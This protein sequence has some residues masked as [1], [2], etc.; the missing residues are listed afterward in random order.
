MQSNSRPTSK[1]IDLTQT[2][3]AEIPSWDGDCGFNLSVSVDYTDCV[4]PDL[5]RV[6]SISTRAGMGTH[7][8]APAHCISGAK[9]VD[10]LVI[11]NLITS[12]VTIHL[13]QFADENYVVMPEIVH[14]FERENGQIEP[15][16]F[17]IFYTGWSKYWNNPIE[18]RNGLRFPSLHEQ[19]AQLL[20][21]RHITGLGTDTLSA[22][23]KGNS[24]PVHRVILG[25]GKYLVENIANA[26]ALPATG[27]Q[28][29]V[30]PM[31]IRDGTEAPAR[32]VALV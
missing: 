23:S 28:I 26:D 25:A 8:D 29:F 15:S 10:D 22:D 6:Q 24:F 19:T 3:C 1:I 17:V 27:A 4:A 18:Y 21:E 2:L 7:I 32:I 20:L 9:T 30:L 12:C 5:F 13:D 14:K 31:K 11:E 16:S